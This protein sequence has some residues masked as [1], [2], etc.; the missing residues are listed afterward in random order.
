M[1]RF[2]VRHGRMSPFVNFGLPLVMPFVSSL[3]CNMVGA[4]LD[5]I[6]DP[7]VQ[8]LANKMNLHGYFDTLAMRS[9]RSTFL[10]V[11]NLDDFGSVVRSQIPCDDGDDAAFFCVVRQSRTDGDGLEIVHHFA[12]V[13]VRYSPKGG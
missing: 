6:D 13:W 11:V 1:G 9:C 10:G 3:F 8:D 2:Y 4:V 5:G 7:T 12:A